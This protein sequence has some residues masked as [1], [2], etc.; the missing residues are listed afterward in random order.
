MLL[1][2]DTLQNFIFDNHPVRGEIVRL[3]NTFQ[4]IINQ[5][6]YPPVIRQLLAEALLAVSLLYGI[7]KHEGKLTLQFQGTGALSLLSV[8]CTHDYHLRGV[9]ECSEGISTVDSLA[10][11]LGNG[12]LLL[13]YEPEG[14]GQRYQSVVEV[15]GNSVAKAIEDYF[16]QSEQLATRIILAADEK[17]A[18]GFMLQ[19]LPSD[20]EKEESWN[21]VLTLAESLTTKEMLSVDNHTLLHRLY[22]QEQVRVFTPHALQFGC[23]CSIYRMEN[24]IIGL[25]KEEALKILEERDSIEVT[26]EFCNHHYEF[27]RVDVEGLFKVDSQ[28]PGS[29]TKH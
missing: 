4:T 19:Q 17:S 10:E 29:E 22:H 28:R 14:Q 13:T 8:R 9:V 27:D 20:F 16:A 1:E 23:S 18:V 21:H 12:T 7:S 5:H 2:H 6:Y 26:C 11:A 15:K 3:D 24:A 25:G